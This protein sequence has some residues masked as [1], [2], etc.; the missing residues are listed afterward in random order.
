MKRH[1]LDVFSLVFGIAF[2][3]MGLVFLITRVDLDLQH[4]RW[5]WPLPLVILGALVIG[6]A[7]RGERRE[8]SE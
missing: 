8:R 7:A 4:L 1:G 6:L 5:V 3:A 2:T